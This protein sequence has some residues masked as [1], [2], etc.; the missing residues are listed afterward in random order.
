MWNDAEIIATGILTPSLHGLVG[1]REIPT[2]PLESDPLPLLDNIHPGT[3]KLL[4]LAA[5]GIDGRVGVIEM[6]KINPLALFLRHLCKLL[7]TFFD[8]GMRDL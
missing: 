8:K 1:R 6:D 4:P 5:F 3:A 7:D 2:R